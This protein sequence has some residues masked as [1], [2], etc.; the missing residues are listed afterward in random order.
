MKMKISDISKEE[1]KEKK[2]KVRKVVKHQNTLR[3]EV[4]ELKSRLE[5]IENQKSEINFNI[6]KK[7][8][9]Q[10]KLILRSEFSKWRNKSDAMFIICENIADK[11]TYNG[12]KLK[13]HN[14]K[15]L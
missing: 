8:A 13:N 5:K 14:I 1:I 12:K 10:L 4:V 2:E 11:F 7:T 6:D 3:E 9:K 15:D